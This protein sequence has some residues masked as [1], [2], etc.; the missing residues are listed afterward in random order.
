MSSQSVLLIGAS[1][2]IGRVVAQEFLVQKSKFA[3]VAILADASK[4]N[5][6]ADIS[7]QGMEIVV[8]SFLEASSFKGKPRPPLF[9]IQYSNLSPGFTTV[10]C[11]LGNYIM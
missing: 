8:G 3:R 2:Y 7:S 6:F 1:G 11:M 5:K 9:P 10:I 4:V